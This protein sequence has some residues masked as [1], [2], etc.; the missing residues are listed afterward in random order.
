M[1][2]RRTLLKAGAGSLLLPGALL[3]C[4]QSETAPL[5]RMAFDRLDKFGLQLSTVTSLMMEDFEGTLERVA[6][7]GYQQVEFSAMGFLGRSVDQ[8]RALLDQNGLEAPV[9]RITPRLPADFFTL[10]R[11]EAMKV[12]FARSA[13]EFFL[14][15][16]AYSLESA[17][18]LEQAYLVLPALGAENFKTLDQ[19]K[20]NIELLNKAGDVC[21]E[22]GVVFGYHN[23]NWEFLPVTD[24]GDE[25]IPYDLMIENTDADRVTFQLDAFWVTKG[26]GNLSD[27]F[28]RY[29]GRFSTCHLKDI[30]DNGDFADVGQGLIDFPTFTRQALAQGTKYFFVERDNPP[31]PEQSIQRSY[32]YLQQMT[33]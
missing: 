16:V 13:P 2:R 14:D 28:S 33:F 17:L 3:G 4:Q 30:D 27:Y 10:P 1:M 12:Y 25:V 11:P 24:S 6:E 21:A 15:N 5:A 9:G 8:V 22:Q 29:A 18:A 7:I 32:A 20:N 26:G 19:V 31:E 23:H